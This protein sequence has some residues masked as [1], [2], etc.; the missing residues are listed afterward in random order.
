MKIYAIFDRVTKTYGKLFEEVN[1]DSAKR[2][3][4]YSFK[5]S[6]YADDMFLSC[7]GSFDNQSG[8]IIVCDD[9]VCELSDA[10]KPFLEVVDNEV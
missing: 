3:V 6:P 8:E 10:V 9:F 1:D 7:L 2:V 5:A 4:G